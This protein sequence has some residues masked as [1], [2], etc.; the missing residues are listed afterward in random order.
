V[1]KI[2]NALSNEEYVRNVDD[3][4]FTVFVTQIFAQNTENFKTLQNYEYVHGLLCYP[5][6]TS[7]T[8]IFQYI[9]YKSLR[10]IQKGKA[11]FVF[12]SSTEGFSPV[13]TFPF[14]D[15]LYYNCQKYN[16][17]PF[18]VIYVS[19]NL[20]DEETIIKYSKERNLKPLQV[21]SFLSFERVLTHDDRAGYDGSG[22]RL[23]SVIEDTHATFNNTKYFTSL[24][25]VNRPYRTLGQF[26]LSHSDIK[27]KALMSHDTVNFHSLEHWRTINHIPE[28]YSDEQV[29]QWIDNLPLIAD[30]DDFNVNWALNTPYKHLFDQTLF[31]VVN[32]TLVDDDQETSMFFSEKSFRPMSYFQPFLIWG[33]P[34]CNHWLGKVGYELYD[35]WFDLSFDF[36]KDHK[37]RYQG[38]LES[39]KETCSKLDNMTQTQKVKW[40]FKRVQTLQRNFNVMTK[41]SFSRQKI[42]N[43][44]VGIDNE[45]NN[46]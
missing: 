36:E 19:S 26:L 7:E 24:S 37:L 44:L 4:V 33:Q 41:S 21:I 1:K 11:F 32:E 31:A 46:P 25:R 30:R 38:L 16:V 40:R 3:T 22:T 28:E 27:D 12:D 43:F 14:F 20:R 17:D 18:N 29:Q 39:I 9:D 8:D 10:K 42:L 15:V 13:H 35:H 23:R 6:W 45:I 34:G 2:Q 5:Q